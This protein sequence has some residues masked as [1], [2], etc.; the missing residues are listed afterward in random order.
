MSITIGAARNG[1]A[2]RVFLLITVLV[3][4]AAPADAQRTVALPTD[5]TTSWLGFH[6]GVRDPMEPEEER[7]LPVV[8]AVFPCSPAHLAGLEPGDL[9]V[10]VNGHDARRPAPFDGPLG[11]EYEVLVDRAGERLT[12][13]LVRA[14]RPKEVGEPVS[15]T[16]MGSPADW[17]C[18]DTTR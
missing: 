14:R 4:V 5:S 12:V 17:K 10:T 7:R 13:K 6:R 1:L 15:T 9:L 18:P 11:G 16:P 2:A 3:A 8:R